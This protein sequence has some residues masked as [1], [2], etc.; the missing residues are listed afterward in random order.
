MGASVQMR[1]AYCPT[2]SMFW[3]DWVT[4]WNDWSHHAQEW[5]RTATHHKRWLCARLLIPHTL[6]FHNKNDTSSV[7]W[8]G[9][10]SSG[11]YRARTNYAANCRTQH[12][13]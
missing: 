1:L 11:P 6:F 8:W 12:Q 7:E 9:C 13:T 4:W 10:S 2:R 5:L 3:T